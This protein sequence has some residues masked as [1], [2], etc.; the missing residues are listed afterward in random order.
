[1]LG[2]SPSSLPY[3][4][5]SWPPPNS[6]VQSQCRGHEVLKGGDDLLRVIGGC[7]GYIGLGAA[8]RS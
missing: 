4:H 3:G 5:K 8:T 1:M 7:M 6:A 2:A